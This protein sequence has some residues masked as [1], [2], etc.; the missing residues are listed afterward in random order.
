ML[1]F[2][3][4]H[5][6]KL[7]AELSKVRFWIDEAGDGE[8]DALKQDLGRLSAAYNAL[9]FRQLARRAD[10]LAATSS[11]KTARIK[12]LADELW[13]ETLDALKGPRF[14]MIPEGDGHLLSMGGG[15]KP[16]TQRAFPSVKAE[17]EQA[18]VSL[19]F[20]LPT[21]SVMHCMRA[22]ETGI[23]VL[24]RSLAL[25]APDRGWH[26]A[27]DAIEKE[28]RRQSNKSRTWRL[29]QGGFYSEAAAEFRH[30]KD[31]WRNHAMHASESYDDKR[32]RKIH[33]HT[34]TFF[35][36]LATRLSEPG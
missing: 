6:I 33:E 11:S 1:D 20:D 19:A 22:L 16:S 9:G 26:S 10:R 8:I 27:L 2:Y 3:A 13:I 29:E 18:A 24:S 12:T 14:H 31:A 4:H 25:P 34:T 17:M 23:R 36:H 35:D 15:L 5:F 28:I 21:A 7:C 30:F 32:A